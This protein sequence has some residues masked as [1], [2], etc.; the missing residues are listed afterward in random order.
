MSEL[1][2]TEDGLKQTVKDA[3]VEVLEERR[4]IL[5]DV[6]EEVLEEFEMIEDYKEVRKSDGLRRRPVFAMSEGEA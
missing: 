6:I 1:G 4:D 2:M 3:L 5:R